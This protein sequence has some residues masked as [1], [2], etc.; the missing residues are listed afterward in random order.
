M[1]DWVLRSAIEAASNWHHGGWQGVRVAINVS[2][3]QLL[4]SNFVQRVEQL[5]AANR[6]PAECIEIELTE[7]VLQTGAETIDTL[8]RLRA[9]GIGI[10]LDDFGAGYSSLASLEQLPLTRVKLDRSLIAGIVDSKRSLAITRATIVL[11][12][13][14]GLQMTAEGIERREQ[15]DHSWRRARCMSRVT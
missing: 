2:A 12:E 6:V 3:R 1:S 10:A 15:L 9:A 14:L 4:D 7:N 5:L 11:C 8:R 13:S